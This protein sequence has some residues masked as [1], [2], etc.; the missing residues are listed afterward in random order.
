MCPNGG[1]VV[2]SVRTEIEAVFADGGLRFVRVEYPDSECILGTIDRND[3]CLA[4]PYIC[5]G[6]AVAEGG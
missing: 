4:K 2:C 1:L 6:I 5:I 3:E